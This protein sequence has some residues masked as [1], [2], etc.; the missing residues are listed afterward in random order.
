MKRGSDDASGWCILR[1][2]E[3][4]TLRLMETL[5]EAGFDAWTP[6]GMT[7]KRVPRSKVTR[8]Q[9][10]PLAATFVFAPY[11]RLPELLILASAG[12]K[13]HPRFSAFRY[14]PPGALLD[15]YPRVRDADIDRV[16]QAEAE[17]GSKH[18]QSALGLGAA[19]RMGSG[20]FEGLIGTVESHRGQHTLVLFPGFNIPVQIPTWQ[21]KGVK[22]TRGKP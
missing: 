22:V 9:P 15:V 16:R 21:L 4:S 1:T 12:R 11:E 2:G 8:R 3:A 10:E 5:N 18:G 19:V 6:I 17:H 20:A 13:P 14:R 7:D